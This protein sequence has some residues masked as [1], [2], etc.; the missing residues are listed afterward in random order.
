MIHSNKSRVRC[1]QTV[2]GN[3]GKRNLKIKKKN[4]LIITP[5]IRDATHPKN[6]WMTDFS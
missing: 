5:H 2:F 4:F 3:K 6:V 1:F